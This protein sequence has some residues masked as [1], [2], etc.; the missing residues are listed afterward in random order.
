M[1]FLFLKFGYKFTHSTQNTHTYIQERKSIIDRKTTEQAVQHVHHST[2]NTRTD[3][4]VRM[5]LWHIWSQTHIVPGHLSPP[6]WVPLDKQPG[7]YRDRIGWGPYLGTICPGGPNWLGTICLGDCIYGDRLSRG[8]RSLG[9]E[10][11]QGQM[12]R[13]QN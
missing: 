5:R 2:Q 12:R 3:I 4:Q 1:L 8:T 13:S 7:N 9:I 11:V 6:Q 10:W